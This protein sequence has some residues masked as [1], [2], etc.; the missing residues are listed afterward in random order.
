MSQC[1]CGC[2]HERTAGVLAASKLSAEVTVEETKARPGALE[3]LQ[4]FGINHC[5][6]AQLSLR[7]ASAAAGVRV[8]DVLEA[9]AGARN[10]T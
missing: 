1:T 10:R 5:C 8:D 3:I 6:G 9:L 4:R 2:G 7:E